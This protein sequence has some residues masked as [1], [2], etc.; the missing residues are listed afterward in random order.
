M[1]NLQPFAYGLVALALLLPAQSTLALTNT[2]YREIE[3][4]AGKA[5]EQCYRHMYRDANAYT[6]CIRDMRRAEQN[7]PLK[8]LGIEY[9]GFVGALSYARVGH[10]NAEQTAAE[11]LTGFR[12]TQKRVGISDEALCRTIEGD[13]KVRIAQTLEMESTPPPQAVSMRMQCI[14]RICKLVPAQ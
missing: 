6:Q 8:K 10:M 14:N 12:Q 1:L 3:T 5:K 13:C 7:A 11:F 2:Q 4:A 9:F